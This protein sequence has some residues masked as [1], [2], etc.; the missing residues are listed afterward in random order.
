MEASAKFRKSNFATK[1]RLFFFV[2]VTARARPHLGILYEFIFLSSRL[3]SCDRDV[4][5]S[6][7]GNVPC[8]CGSVEC[9][10]DGEDTNT[11]TIMIETL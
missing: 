11:N 10:E 5:L 2:V 7:D 1:D 4:D 3:A 9:C 6:K 8:A